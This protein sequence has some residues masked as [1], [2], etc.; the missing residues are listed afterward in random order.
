MAY[1]A[2][3]ELIES[4]DYLNPLLSKMFQNEPCQRRTVVSA[5]RTYAKDLET[6]NPTRSQLFTVN[7][8][9]AEDWMATQNRKEIF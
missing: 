2:Y 3:Q 1:N 6:V 9:A 7:A 8:D 5:L 4:L